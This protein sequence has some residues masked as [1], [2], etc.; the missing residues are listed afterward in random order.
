MSTPC[1]SHQLLLFTTFCT[2]SESSVIRASSCCPARCGAPPGVTFPSPSAG[3]G[4]QPSAITSVLLPPGAVV[5]RSEGSPI[6]L[7]R[8]G[9][10]TSP[11]TCRPLGL[12]GS[13]SSSGTSLPSRGHAGCHPQTI[14]PS[15]PTHRGRA[16]RL[17]LPPKDT[18]RAGMGEKI[19]NPRRT[20][21]AETAGE[22]PILPPHGHPGHHSPL[23]TP[24]PARWLSRRWPF[25]G[26]RPAR[27]APRTSAAAIWRRE[28]QG[29][30]G[31]GRMQISDGNNPPSWP[32][33]GSSR[34]SEAVG[35]TLGEGTGKRRQQR[36]EGVEKRWREAV[37]M[38]EAKEPS[39]RNSPE[40][41]KQST[42]DR[43]RVSLLPGRGSKR[44]LSHEGAVLGGKATFSTARSRLR[45]GGAACALLPKLLLPRSRP[46]P[47]ALPGEHRAQGH[48]TGTRPP[49]I[50]P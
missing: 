7:S 30:A 36:R 29:R 34:G 15:T 12:A 21:P 17:L 19:N 8:G 20:Q 45:E 1:R 49:Q 46:A 6:P 41:P 16:S 50:C 39:A 38:L 28:E 31:G 42:E 14:S 24:A 37:E 47:S 4:S 5:L 44:C 35:R 43:D 11:L 9:A 22:P 2:S 32:I 3:P 25:Q 48:P 27:A 40:K 10:L 18:G 33:S 13:A 23:L 26:G